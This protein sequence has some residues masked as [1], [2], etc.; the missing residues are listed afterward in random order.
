MPRPLCGSANVP[1]VGALLILRR[2]LF[3]FFASHAGLIGIGG[4]GWCIAGVRIAQAGIRLLFR[5]RCRPP[6]KRP[7]RLIS[8]ALSAALHSF[9][10]LAAWVV[11]TD[12][13]TIPSALLVLLLLIGILFSHWA[14]LGTPG[15]N[16]LS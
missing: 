12:W 1:L 15:L 13:P 7:S 4:A 11:I 8:G 6:Q 14:L 9:A 3:P 2:V 10:S 16:S 5:A